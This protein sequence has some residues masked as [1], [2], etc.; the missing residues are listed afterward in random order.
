MPFV[1]NDPRINRTGRKPG[2]KDRK[3]QSA[4][5]IW[6]LLMKEWHKL[7]PNE[8]ARYSMDVFKM[9]FERAISQM[10]KEASDSVSNA[11]K[12]LE[13]L[14]ALESK[15]GRSTD[16][17]TGVKAKVVD[18]SASPSVGDVPPEDGR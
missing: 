4:Q 16:V 13:E 15:A 2:S 7:T 5:A 11:S 3:W 14:K 8:R 9:H 1:P 10:P 6:D 12:L 17:E 18:G